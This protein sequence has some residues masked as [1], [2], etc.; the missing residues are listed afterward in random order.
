[1]IDVNNDSING[2]AQGFSS[3]NEIMSYSG[4]NTRIDI[5][6]DKRNKQ[7]NTKKLQSNIETK[8]NTNKNHTVDNNKIKE[9]NKKIIIIG[10]SMLRYETPKFLSKNYNFVNVRFHRG[11]TTEDIVDFIK[12]V[13]KKKPDA[14]IIHAGTNDLTNGTNT[15]KQVR[16]IAKTIKEMEDSGKMGIGFSGI[17]QRVDRNFKDQIKETNDKLKRYCEGNGFVYVDNDNI[18][19][20]SLNK[21]L[22]HLNKAG[23]KLFSKNLIDC[24]K[25]L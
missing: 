1:M 19:E 22:L 2:I 15:M 11:A 23:N 18:N 20:K 6:T 25:N 12:P 9:K 3:S 4:S 13:I 14:V 5:T 8:D 7:S 17:I 21:S 24:L 10:D 16:E